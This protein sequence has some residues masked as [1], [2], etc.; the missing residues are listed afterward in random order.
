[1]RSEEGKKMEHY[2]KIGSSKFL[3]NK[4]IPACNTIC[5]EILDS[6]LLIEEYSGVPL[7]GILISESG[8]WYN[9][10]DPRWQPKLWERVANGYFFE[11]HTSNS[12]S[13]LLLDSKDEEEFRDVVYTWEAKKMKLK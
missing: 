5:S 9:T 6:M 8:E 3:L 4:T 7:L 1:M 2:Y 11:G 10:I 13:K 12:V